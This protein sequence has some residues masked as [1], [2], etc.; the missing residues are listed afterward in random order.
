MVAMTEFTK[1]KMHFTLALLATLFA[2][3]PVI[4]KVGDRGFWYGIEDHQVW[5]ENDY[6]YG[7]L[8]GLL[9]LTV[10]CFAL[11]MRSEQRKAWTEKVGNYAYGLAAIV[12]PLYGGLAVASWLGEEL[13]E[14]GWS[15]AVKIAPMVPLALGG[16][17]L[18]VSQVLVLWLRRRLSDQDRKAKIEHL[19][20]QEMA[21]LNRAPEMFDSD[22]YDL[23]V[24][25]AWKALE[26][27]LRRSLL[28]H[29]YS[30]PGEKSEAV[31]HAATR[32]GILAPSALGAV[33]ELRR[34]WHIAVGTEPLS[35]EAADK[36]LKTT[37]DLLATIPVADPKKTT[38]P[39]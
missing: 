32:A 14:T 27:R 5:L 22:H 4:D 38:R 24:I 37:R 25:E 11:S 33:E 28:L 19:A 17:W 31:I 20:Q 30:N 34:Q 7:V 1:T 6:V 29:G 15:W 13:E 35:R 8:A 21:A 36:T 16:F 26:A 10:Y 2:L 18:L 12:L 39:A 9:G 23:S 3:H